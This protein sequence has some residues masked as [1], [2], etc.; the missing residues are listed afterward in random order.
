MVKDLFSTQSS[1]YAKYR[2]SYP[3]ELFDYITGFVKEKNIAWD[4]ATGN[5]Q[6]AIELSHYFKK[7]EASDI[8]E[9]QLS[10]AV[11]AP[12]V[13]Y[14]KCSADATPFADNSFDLITVATAYHWLDPIAFKKEAERVGKK[15]CVIAIWAYNLFICE[16]D[17]INDIIQYFYK[18]IVG[19]YWD[20]G[21]RHVE[22]AY[23]DVIFDFTL[24][25]TK[26][27]TMVYS[28]TMEQ[29]LGYLQSWSAFHGYIKQ[30][31]ASPLPL[32]EQQVKEK[33]KSA[34]AKEFSFP[35]FLKMGTITK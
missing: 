19:P 9:G 27:F 10:N 12:N 6:A 32:I 23:A 30:N 1:V 16:D 31:N 22:N 24:L 29:F 8:S 17:A 21:R 13:H 33:W 34:E 3:K 14:T 35:L 4:C 2:P 25:P 20:P 11:Q 28:W 26:D 5:G 18:D 7:V 15:D